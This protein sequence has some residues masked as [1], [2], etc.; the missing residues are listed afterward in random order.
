MLSESATGERFVR[1]VWLGH[2]IKPFGVGVSSASK[3]IS[4]LLFEISFVVGS[5]ERGFVF[6]VFDIK[7]G[8]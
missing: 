4:S 6:G 8:R 7:Y 1:Y 2:N 3:V 5:D